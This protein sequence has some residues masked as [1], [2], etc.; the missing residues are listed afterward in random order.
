MYMAAVFDP[1]EQQS[2]STYM[3]PTP[4]SEPVPLHETSRH[5]EQALALTGSED[6]DEDLHMLITDVGNPGGRVCSGTRKLFS[7]LAARRVRA[8][9]ASPMDQ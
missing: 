3:G 8:L 9:G 4:P 2:R 7:H 5:G 6:T 1:L